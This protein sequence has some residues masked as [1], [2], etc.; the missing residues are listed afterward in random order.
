MPSFKPNPNFAQELAVEPEYLD[1]LE[2]AAERGAEQARDLAH[3]IMPE[4]RGEQIVVE[5]D[6][7]GV[8]IANLDHGGHLDEFGSAN[9]EAYA[10][11]RRGALAAGLRIS[12]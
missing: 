7:E 12:E 6:E 5:S 2:E 1:V 3:A 8:R 10:P 4:G 9:N 11:L